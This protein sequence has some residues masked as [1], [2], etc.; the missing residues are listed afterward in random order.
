MR[1]QP[2]HASIHL[3]GPRSLAGAGF[4]PLYLVQGEGQILQFL[5]FWRTDT[6]TSRLLRVAVSWFQYQSGLGKPILTHVH[7]H[8][9]HIESRWLPSLRGFLSRIKATIELD[10]PYIPPLQRQHDLYIMESVL[11]SGV[12]TPAEVCQL[13]YCR[14]HLQVTTLS[15]LTQ[16]NGLYI[17]ESFFEGNTE[18]LSSTSNWLHF[19][20]SMETLEDSPRMVG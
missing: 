15:D 2:Q 19:S 4:I 17:N 20:Q 3:F 11:S 10:T 13:N 9:P 12:F 7:Q 8:L 5:K 1:V 18:P 6:P 16:A 14:L